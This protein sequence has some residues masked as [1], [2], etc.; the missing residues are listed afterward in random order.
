[1]HKVDFTYGVT[2]LKVGIRRGIPH[3]AEPIYVEEHVASLCIVFF[4]SCVVVW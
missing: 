4:G 3:N 2:A 1:M